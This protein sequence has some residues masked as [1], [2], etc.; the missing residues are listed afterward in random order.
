M[1][2]KE[3]SV[4][5]MIDY[6]ARINRLFRYFYHMKM[7]S[8]VWLHIVLTLL[9]LDATASAQDDAEASI[10]EEPV[11]E[12]EPDESFLS[13]TER[14]ET[15]S[16]EA[17]TRDQSDASRTD[18]TLS[19]F[20]FA[21]RLGGFYSLGSWTGI[22]AEIEFE[23]KLH[24]RGYLSLLTSFNGGHQIDYERG[25]YLF[26]EALGYRHYLPNSSG[27]AWTAFGGVSFGYFTTT[28]GQ[29][30]R[31]HDWLHVGL[32][33]KGGYYFFTDE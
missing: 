9:V 32:K 22:L 3:R 6:R 12:E 20:L 13:T 11:L 19:G 26:S 29:A 18:L 2:D 23:F 28:Q 21:F 30:E 4:E 16:T 15:G 27:D 25:D 5:P 7:R 24:N 33:A 1:N 31:S 17:V 8:R 10:I 14:D